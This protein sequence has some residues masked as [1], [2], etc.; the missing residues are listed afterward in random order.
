[1]KKNVDY[2]ILPQLNLIIELFSGPIDI[3]DAVELKKREIEDEAYNPN[4]NHII[5]LCDIVV[6]TFYEEETQKYI[7]SIKNN[8]NNWGKGKCNFNIHPCSASS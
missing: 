2:K 3:N 7:D 1:M 6:Y 8:E 5:S 4:N